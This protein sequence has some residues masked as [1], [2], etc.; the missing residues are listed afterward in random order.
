MQILV[1]T[2]AN[3]FLNFVKTPANAKVRVLETLEHNEY[4]CVAY[5]YWRD[6]M[7]ISKDS[8]RITMVLHATTEYI[9]YLAKQI[10]IWEG[11]MSVVFFVPTPQETECILKKHK[12]CSKYDKLDILHFQLFEYF[13]YLFDTSKISLHFFFIKSSFDKCPHVILKG[14]KKP[15]NNVIEKFAKTLS[16]IKS[17]PKFFRHY[18]INPARNI[19]RIGKRT[20]LFLSGDIENYSS[21]NYESKVSKLAE[22]VILNNNES[23]LVLVH[24]RFEIRENAPVPKLKSELYELYKKKKAFVFHWFFYRR[25]H[26][27]A[28]LN[29]WFNSEENLNETSISFIKFNN[30]LAWEPQFVGDDRVPFHDERFPYRVRSNSHLA[31]IMCF[32]NFSFAIMNDVFTVHTGVKKWLKRFEKQEA[33]TV[34]VRVTETL[35]HNE[36]Y[37]VAYYYWRDSMNITKDSKRITL[38]LHATSG[39]INYLAKQIEIWEGPISVAMLVPTPYKTECIFYKHKICSQYD[40]TKIWHFQLLEYFKNIFDTTKISLHFF[41]FKG[42]FVKC[43]HVILKGIKKPSGDLI[44]KYAYALSIIKSLPKYFYHYPINAARNI[45]RIGKRTRLFLSGDIENYSSLNYESKVS[46]LA[47]KVILNNNETNLVLVHRRFEILSRVPVPKLKS[48]LYELYKE[49]KAFVFHWFFFKSGHEISGLNDWFETKE[50]F[51]NTSISFLMFKNSSQ[52]EPQF[53]GDDRVPFHDERFRYR[54][55]S[56]SHLSTIMCFQNFS[57]AI[58]NDVFTV[59]KGVKKMYTR[60]ELS[61][62]V[63]AKRK[64]YRLM[65]EFN[66][67]ITTYYPHMSE[68]CNQID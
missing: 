55:R 13:R 27:I 24:R 3:C 52:W 40:R 21:S 35:E 5:Y 61:E 60:Y 53:V 67:N 19:A 50:D 42:E 66:Y 31:H 18:P 11:P 29:D 26:E 58:M 23:N 10:A 65:K 36:R 34:K 44:V 37:C 1:V 39:Y 16:L 33:N 57:F 32:Q 20:R 48:E 54:L 51:N 62:L 56:N 47:E 41:F 12:L 6:S 17:L 22:K 63:S 43:P 46:R 14:I 38:V 30:R 8:K 2:Y 9:N 28:G 68:N 7:N 25:G 49:Q 4:Y 45:A 64:L 59:H 15:K